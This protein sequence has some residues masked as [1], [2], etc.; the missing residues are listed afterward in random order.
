LT[1]KLFKF[2]ID[3]YPEDFRGALV[4]T[5]SKANRR[6]VVQISDSNE[7][8]SINDE[9]R[10]E[11][12]NKENTSTHKDIHLNVGTSTDEYKNTNEGNGDTLPLKYPYRLVTYFL[13]PGFHNWTNAI[14]FVS[15]FFFVSKLRWHLAKVRAALFGGT[16][17]SMSK[18]HEIKMHE[19][20][21]VLTA[22]EEELLR[23]AGLDTYLVSIISQ[24][25]I[26]TAFL[27]SNRSTLQMIRFARFGF[28]VCFYPFLFACITV[29]PIYITCDT[30]KIFDVQNNEVLAAASGVIDGLFR[31][32]INR[33]PPGSGK[34]Y[35]IIVFNFFLYFFVLR[36]LWLEW[37]IIIKVSLSFMSSTH[38]SWNQYSLT[39]N[40]APPSFSF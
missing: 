7:S 13:P 26:I 18:R 5:K 1:L 35:W 19:D 31:L 8:Y 20:L 6:L 16:N 10:I 40:K 37:E 28:D 15:E 3:L 11:S 30:E 24:L 34:M 23:C 17:I 2:I 32:T 14:R 22:P 33:I 9:P 4:E 12:I 36:R 39:L 21:I 25:H 29:F 38:C 27:C